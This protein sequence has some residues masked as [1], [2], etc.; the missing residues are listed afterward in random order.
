VSRQTICAIERGKY[1]P[2]LEVAFRIANILCA[3]IEDV[4]YYKLIY[5]GISDMPRHYQQRSAVVTRHSEPAM[6]RAL[7]RFC[8][9][10]TSDAAEN[11]RLCR[12]TKKPCTQL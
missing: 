1:L 10:S 6:M 12:D 9:F 8:K 3:S 4:F 7:A 5:M 11:L 2:S